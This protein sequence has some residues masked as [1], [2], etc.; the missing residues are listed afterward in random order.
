MSP[1]SRRRFLQAASL[2]LLGTSASGWFPLL[3]DELAAN[4]QRRRQ[5]VLLW[6][7]GGPSQTDT[8]DMKPGH[9]NG[10]Q[11]SEIATQDPRRKFYKQLPKLA[12]MPPHLALIRGMSTSEGDHDRGTYLMRTGRRPDPRIQY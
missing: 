4:K 10:G 7:T 12:K 9:R 11:F 5:C 6:M 1:Q 2:G 3:A 8:F